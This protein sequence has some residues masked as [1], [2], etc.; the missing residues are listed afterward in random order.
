MKRILQI[1]FSMK[2]AGSCAW[3]LH[4]AFSELPGY[5]SEV[6]SLYSEEKEIPGFFG[7]SRWA[8]SKAKLNNR[9][10]KLT[11]KYDPV[12]SGLFTSPIIGTDVSEHECVQRADVIYI[13]WVQMGFLTLN[14]IER[15]IQ[16]GKQIIFFMHDMWTIT[17]G[18]HNSFDCTGYERDCSDCPILLDNKSIASSQLKRKK[19]MFSHDNVSFVSPSRWLQSCAQHSV[20]TGNHP[21][22]YIPNY[23]KSE[24][25]VPQDKVAVRQMLGIPTDSKVIAF[26]AVNVLSPYKGFTYLEQALNY[27]PE[28]YKEENVQILIFGEVWGKEMQNLFPYNIKFLGYLNE[29]QDIANAYGAADVFVIPSIADNQPTV[30]VESLSC[31]VPVVGFEVGGIPDM[32]QHRSNG[33]LAEVKNYKDFAEGIKFCLEE[34]IKGS[35]LD[36]FDPEHVMNLHMELINERDTVR[37]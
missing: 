16:T 21:V 37:V 20:V 22:H 9:L 10:H 19:E 17:G 14:G 13:H 18:C 29:E 26:G 30:I 11:V 36:F 12:K 4:R 2:S 25:F 6:L 35:Q 28:I 7:L 5:T 8:V 33:Y 3:K 27:L 1:Q 24:F 23:F 32:I 31:G 15:L 34:E